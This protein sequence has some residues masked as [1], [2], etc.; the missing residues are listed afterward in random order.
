MSLGESNQ[1]SNLMNKIRK[2]EIDRPPGFEGIPILFTINGKST[3]DV[4]KES[5]RLE[6]AFQKEIVHRLKGLE[7][8]SSLTAISLFPTI[9]DP[10]IASMPDHVTYRRDGSV[11]V[12][13]NIDHGRWMGSSALEKIDLFAENIC[14]CIGKIKGSRL[15]PADRVKLLDIVEQSR[16][17]LHQRS[18]H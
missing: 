3:K 10:D 6:L 12:G 15:V 13:L 4:S 18:L 8:S 9:L 17:I 1:G 2:P 14:S 5:S 16:Q 7:I 11:Y